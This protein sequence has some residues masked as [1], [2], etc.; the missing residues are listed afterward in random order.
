[1]KVTHADIIILQETTSF[2]QQKIT[3]AF[4]KEYPYREFRD[5]DKAGGF[6]IISKYP[7]KTKDYFPPLFGWNSIWI[8]QVQ[9]PLGKLQLANIHLT[10]PVIKEGDIGFLANAVFS[11]MPKRRYEVQFIHS[12]LNKNLPAI[13]AGDFNEGEIGSAVKYLRENNFSDA[14]QNN[15]IEDHT[16]EWNWG[17]FKFYDRFDRFFYTT[18]LQLTNIQVIHLGDSDHYPVVADFRKR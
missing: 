12:L 2:W 16:W 15:N 3:Q 17:L 11:S 5:N 8:M 10:P 13:I 7:F 18:P 4:S 6:G 9:T 1:M 14:W